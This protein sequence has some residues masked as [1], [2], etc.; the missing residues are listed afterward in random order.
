MSWFLGVGDR[1]PG[2]SAGAGTSA[3]CEYGEE[4]VTLLALPRPGVCG[5]EMYLFGYISFG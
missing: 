2:G 1:P 3:A 5:S 4:N